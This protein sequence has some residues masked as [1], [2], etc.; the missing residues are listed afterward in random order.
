[1]GDELAAASNGGAFGATELKAKET[2]AEL[3]SQVK[4]A[5]DQAAVKAKAAAEQAAVKAK[6]LY[7]E[8]KAEAEKQAQQARALVVEKP[9][10][11]VGLALLAGFLLGHLMSA[12]R[13]QVIYLKDRR[14]L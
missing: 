2:A 3:K 1:M 8:A 4:T 12:G 5:A 6:A 11:A 7:G 14:P 9:Y 10:A 13:P